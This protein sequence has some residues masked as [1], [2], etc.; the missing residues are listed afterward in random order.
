MDLRAQVPGDMMRGCCKSVAGL[1]RAQQFGF[2]IFP[3]WTHSHANMRGEYL[4][5]FTVRAASGSA[6]AASILLCTDGYCVRFSDSHCVLRRIQFWAF[7]P[8]GG[9]VLAGFVSIGAE[10]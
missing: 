8:V 6:S 4:A 3:F 7:T 10:L 5:L 2:L 1:I 9:F